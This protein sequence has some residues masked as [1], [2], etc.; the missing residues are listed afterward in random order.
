MGKWI[1]RAFIL[2]GILLI[3]PKIMELYSYFGDHTPQRIEEKVESGEMDV[4]KLNK[5]ILLED[6]R[7]H[8]KNLYT[9]PSETIL[10]YVVRSNENGWSFPE[11]A[12]RLKTQEGKSLL[13]RGGSMRNRGKAEFIISEYEPIPKNTSSIMVDFEWFDRSFQT[14]ISLE[15]EE[16]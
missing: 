15:Q 3:S 4:H 5:E 11:G 2:V 12:L 1:R 6:D 16:S 10:Q 7:I 13:N 14:E 8:L 9:S